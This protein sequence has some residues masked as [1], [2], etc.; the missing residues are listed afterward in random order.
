MSITAANIRS[1]KVLYFSSI[2]LLLQRGKAQHRSEAEH[3]AALG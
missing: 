1:Q 3:A 2:N